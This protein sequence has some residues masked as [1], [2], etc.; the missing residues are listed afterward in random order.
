MK[1]LKKVKFRENFK[2]FFILEIAE[3]K[4]ICASTAEAD[5]LEDSDQRGNQT[6]LVREKVQIKQAKRALTLVQIEKATPR[7][8]S[9]LYYLRN[10]EAVGFLRQVYIKTIF[11]NSF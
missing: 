3:Y 6:K 7:L 9:E 4:K 8:L 11:L 2:L 5:T 1:Q 10:A